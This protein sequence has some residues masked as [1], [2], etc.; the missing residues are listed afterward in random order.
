MYFWFCF[1]LLL[2]IVNFPSFRRKEGGRVQIVL[3][4]KNGAVESHVYGVV[5]WLCTFLKSSYS[6]SG[7]FHVILVLKP[8]RSFRFEVKNTKTLFVQRSCLLLISLFFFSI[9]GALNCHKR[10][11]S[12]QSYLIKCYLSPNLISLEA[13]K[14]KH[15]EFF[16]LLFSDA[17]FVTVSTCLQSMYP[18]LL[19]ISVKLVKLV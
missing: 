8:N 16:S 6:I 12:C 11:I 19:V 2:E 15:K 17:A 13:S 1:S 5:V 18:E 14:H 4:N 10:C 3:M 9:M 7:E